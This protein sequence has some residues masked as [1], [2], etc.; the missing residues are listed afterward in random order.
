MKVLAY[1]V[2]N[3]EVEGVFVNDTLPLLNDEVHSINSCISA[4]NA[5]GV[6]FGI[7][8]AD[9]TK[10]LE[11]MN[12]LEYKKL[13]K[14]VAAHNFVEGDT[15]FVPLP[16]LQFSKK[17]DEKL[18]NGLMRERFDKAVLFNYINQDLAYDGFIG[19]EDPEYLLFI[20]EDYPP[21]PGIAEGLYS[22][23]Y[24]KNAEKWNI[25]YIPQGQF[26]TVNA[27]NTTKGIVI[28]GGKYSFDDKLNWIPSL[29]NLL[30]SIN[31]E[32]PHIRIVGMCLAHQIFGNI[33]EG[34][35][36]RNPS[37]EC[38]YVVENMKAVEPFFNLPLNIKITSF[39][40]DCV[41][42]LP[43]NAKLL[44]S[45]NTCEIEIMA[46]GNNIIS[47]QGH[48]EFTSFF[49]KNF[50][51]VKTLEEG[52]IDNQTFTIAVESADQYFSDSEVVINCLNSFLRGLV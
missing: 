32:R 3:D 34:L 6:V 5:L 21:W 37:G 44:Y 40:N 7:V 8:G 38:V 2:L 33:F 10:S 52:V 24:K 14:H 11:Q 46:I 16:G 50:H 19:Y 47:I 1:H 42:R 28:T 4:A 18:L 13:L 31:N 45:S 15:M 20:L 25:Y 36:G 9:Q 29:E 48:P 22:G 35:S 49:F 23:F 43:K 26:P 51:A 39:H 30:K 12:N 17:V 41:L 27:L